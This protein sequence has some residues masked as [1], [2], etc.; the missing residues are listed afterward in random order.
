MRVARWT[1]ARAMRAKP[2][3]RAGSR[4]HHP[5][6]T[7]QTARV[8]PQQATLMFGDAE[9][10]P[11][12]SFD[13]DATTTSNSCQSRAGS[14]YAT[15][16]SSVRSS[17]EGS[18]M[19]RRRYSGHGAEMRCVDGGTCDADGPVSGGV[20]AGR[21]HV[22]R[23]DDGGRSTL[24]APSITPSSADQPDLSW[25]WSTESGPAAHATSA[26][27][28]SSAQ[29]RVRFSGVSKS[30][31]A[32]R[33]TKMP[34]LPRAACSRVVAP[35]VDRSTNCLADDTAT[36][37]CNN[38]PAKAARKLGNEGAHR[39][40][41]D[42]VE[43]LTRARSFALRFKRSE[44]SPTGSARSAASELRKAGRARSHLH[45][46]RRSLRCWKSSVDSLTTVR[47]PQAPLGAVREVHPRC[48][49]IAPR[50]RSRTS[51]GSK[52]HPRTVGR[53]I[54]GRL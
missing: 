32:G 53:R 52:L 10:G 24:S 9:N 8:P 40:R 35:R 29:T 21:T 48:Q 20:R 13:A 46:E 50:H 44:T 2:G 30:R 34:R 36:R 15:P 45:D 54:V 18:S 41:K 6:R 14:K 17:A 12:R 47:R 11:Q 23:D 28:R 26:C 27:S 33:V 37:A 25:S 1:E 39:V 42:D 49:A 3:T 5:C 51:F 43:A 4:C 19:Y 7:G 16:R 22:A 38:R 31:S